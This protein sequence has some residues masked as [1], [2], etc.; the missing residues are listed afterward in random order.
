MRRN[1]FEAGFH[2]RAAIASK[3]TMRQWRWNF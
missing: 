1:K 2:D 3:T